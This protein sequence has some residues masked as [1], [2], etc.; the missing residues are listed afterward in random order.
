[1][2]GQFFF[3]SCVAFAFVGMHA[4]FI[5]TAKRRKWFNGVLPQIFKFP[6]IEIKIFFGMSMGM[7]NVALGVL[8][9]TNTAPGWKV[10][11]EIM[12]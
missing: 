4:L 8:S 10:T 1:M 2:R 3:M 6:H 9:N 5:Y 11:D 7:L 12:S